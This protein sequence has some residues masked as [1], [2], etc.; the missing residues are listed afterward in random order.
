MAK[1]VLRIT[2]IALLILV[3]LCALAL[4]G[5]FARQAYVNNRINNNIGGVYTNPALQTPVAVNG[6]T[7]I[8]QKI[9]CGYACI[10]M[11]AAWQG[12]EVTEESLYT[13]NN[14]TIS[15]AM[16]DGF[17][18]ETQKQLP[19]FT[20]QKHKNLTNTQLIETAYAS[21]A[22]GM[23]VP[24]E[25]ASPMQVDGA[26]VWTLH[27][28]II[29]GINIPGDAITVQN[30]YGYEETYTVEELLRATRYDSYEN[31][32]WFFKLGFAAG[33]FTKNTLYT[34]QA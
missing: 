26:T 9:S 7:T 16:G 5:L 34:L 10:E 19:E 4:G 22:A 21:L 31:M 33:M 32:E 3:L 18:T 27:F 23:P 6:I 25:F 8:T 13:Q 20:V 12:K 1:K 17:L 24:I 15:T 2:G 11:L 29:T 14:Q 28:A 30:P